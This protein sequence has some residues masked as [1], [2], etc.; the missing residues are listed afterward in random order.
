M[1][2]L[3]LEKRSYFQYFVLLLLP[4]RCLFEIAFRKIY[5]ASYVMITAPYQS[6]YEH[7]EQVMQKRKMFQKK[8]RIE[9]KLF[10]DP[11]PLE[12]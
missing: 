9:I 3:I 11:F 1:F 4:M 12:Q 8:Q 7:G 5:F 2:H 10:L 6:I